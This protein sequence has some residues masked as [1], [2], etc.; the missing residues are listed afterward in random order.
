MPILFTNIHTLPSTDVSSAGMPFSY[1]PPNP[2]FALVGLVV[3]AGH[4]ID[5]VAPLFAE[6]LDDGGIGQQIRGPSFG[7][8]GGSL[9]ELMVAPGHVVTGIQTRSGDYVDA[10]RLLQAKWEGGAIDTATAKWTEWAGAPNMGGVER[11]ERLV[12]PQGGAMAVGIAGR[13][14]RYVDNL[15]LIAA[16]VVRVAGTVIARGNARG[17]RSNVAAG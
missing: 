14:N 13:A 4:W 2:G 5:Q 10:V 6:L 16:D 7:G 11:I 8:E 9:H 1:Q 12:E 17:A 15:T 3:R